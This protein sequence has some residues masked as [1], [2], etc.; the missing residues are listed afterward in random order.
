M[1]R[2]LLACYT[3][4][5]RLL[6]LIADAYGGRR[7]E[8]HRLAGALHARLRYG[9]IDTI[10]QTGLHEFLTEI[11]DQTAVLGRSITDFYLA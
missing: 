5:S 6:D 10:F 7:G 1:P 8:C 4:V 2:S 3:Q 9:K 11:I